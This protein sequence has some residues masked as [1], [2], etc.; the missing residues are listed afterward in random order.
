ME[1]LIGVSSAAYDVIV[2]DSHGMQYKNAKRATGKYFLILSEITVIFLERID[3]VVKLRAK[4]D[5]AV[6][7]RVKIDLYF[8][9]FL[10][11]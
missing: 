10:L 5:F 6:K 2:R 11:Y 3:F 9:Q 7:F 1:I 4:K 8:I